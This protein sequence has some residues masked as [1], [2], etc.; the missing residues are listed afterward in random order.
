MCRL[1]HRTA[2][3]GPVRTVVWEGRSRETPPYPDPQAG[4]GCKRVVH[5]APLAGR[6]RNSRQR[7]SGE[8]ELQEA[9]CRGDW[10]SAAASWLTVGTARWVWPLGY[11]ISLAFIRFHSTG[12]RERPGIEPAALFVTLTS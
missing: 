10:L 12:G 1:I 11:I 5:L 6:G 7:I 3:Y 2:V 9:R 4:R 8:G